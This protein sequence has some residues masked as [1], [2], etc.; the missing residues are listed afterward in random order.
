[1]DA[2]QVQ[3]LMNA[4]ESAGIEVFDVA[5]DLMN[6]M[7]NH[8]SSLVKVDYSNK[9]FVNFRSSKYTG[10]HPTY[11]DNVEVVAAAF[12]DI[13]EFRTAGD[14]DKVKAF[15][16]ALGLSL[17]DDEYNIILKIDKGNYDIK[18]ETGDYISGFHYLSNKQIAE[19]T[20][21]EKEQYE[22]DLEAYEKAKHDYIGQN[23]AASISL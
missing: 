10:S 16:D 23:M 11:A 7:F 6:H 19:L 21:E 1:M 8:K 2:S 20:P 12:E 13:H 3:K 17:T 18:P 15:V 5:D 22:A 4:L 14:S 9:L